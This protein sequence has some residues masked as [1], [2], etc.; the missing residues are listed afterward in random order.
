[1]HA[2][3]FSVSADFLQMLSRVRDELNR[4]ERER[5]PGL[6]S[7]ICSPDSRESA[8]ALSCP[9]EWASLPEEGGVEITRVD[10]ALN[11]FHS[12]H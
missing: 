12:P 5:N 1:M 3:G 9:G 10:V 8:L 11:A 2:V 7:L 6:P 4:L